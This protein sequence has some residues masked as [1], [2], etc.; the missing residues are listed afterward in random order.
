MGDEGEQ[1]LLKLDRIDFDRRVAIEKELDKVADGMVNQNVEFDESETIV[2]Y[3]SLYG[4]KL[5]NFHK[6]QVKRKETRSKN[7]SWCVSWG[8]W[9]TE[10]VS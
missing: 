7:V 10:N 4:V 5:Y 2:I 1:Q 3:T 9:R 6:K 8:K